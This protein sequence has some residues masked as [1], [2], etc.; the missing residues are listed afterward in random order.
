MYC[1]YFYFIFI[2]LFML[3]FRVYS[4]YDI[5]INNK[6]YFNF[7]SLIIRDNS[8]FFQ[9]TEK[10]RIHVHLLLKSVLFAFKDTLERLLN[11]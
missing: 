7:R 11:R 10:S 1:L 5:I 9:S 6:S 3:L 8:A 4:L 2:Y